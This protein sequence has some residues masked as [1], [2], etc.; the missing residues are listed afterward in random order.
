VT[1]IKA[2]DTDQIESDEEPEIDIIKCPRAV[3]KI[4]F[5]NSN[6]D[7]KNLGSDVDIDILQ[8]K[9]NIKT[10]NSILFINKPK[11]FIEECI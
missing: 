11:A 9:I 10:S 5:L 2:D 1:R 3:L 6:L 7:I 8:A 4:N